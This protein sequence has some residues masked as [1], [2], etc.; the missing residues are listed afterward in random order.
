MHNG[1]CVLNELD[2]TVY[3]PTQG[4]IGVAIAFPFLLRSKDLDSKCNPNFKK[5]TVRSV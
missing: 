3:D 2:F 5:T 4:F 1:T